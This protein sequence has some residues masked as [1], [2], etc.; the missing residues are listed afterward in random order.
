MRVD[1]G[2]LTREDFVWKAEVR[3]LHQ[4]HNFGRS[5]WKVAWE[6]LAEEGT[7]P[8]TEGLGSVVRAMDEALNYI[9]LSRNFSTTREKKCVWEILGAV[10]ESEGS[11]HLGKIPHIFPS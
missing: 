2:C 7:Y 6:F 1:E 9:S 8:P 10:G 11:P 4:V 5:V 3:V